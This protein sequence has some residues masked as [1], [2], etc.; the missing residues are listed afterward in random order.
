MKTCAPIEYK[1]HSLITFRIFQDLQ[2]MDKSPILIIRVRICIMS[3]SAIHSERV[4]PG[5]RPPTVR[6]EQS[7]VGTKYPLCSGRIRLVVRGYGVVMHGDGC[8]SAPVM[9]LRVTPD[10]VLAE[11]VAIPLTIKFST[12]AFSADSGMEGLTNDEWQLRADGGPAAGRRKAAV[13]QSVVGLL[14]AR[15][16]CQWHGKAP[17]A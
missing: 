17:V 5:T 16:G 2:R 9:R 14:Q 7:H 3:R 8:Q 15:C 1:S 6:R 11:P 4:K 12:L 13:D 10:P